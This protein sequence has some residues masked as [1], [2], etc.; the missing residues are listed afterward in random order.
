VPPADGQV[1][2]QP[3]PAPAADVLPP[4]K[5]VERERDWLRRN[6]GARYDTAAAL[7]SR[8]L[9]EAPGLHGGPRSS[10]GDAPTDLAAVRLY[11]TGSTT[12][13]D[14]AI[15]SAA[16]GPH[17]PLARC[18]ASGLR[19]LPSHRG[20]AIVRAALTPAERAW[21]RENMVVV[22]RSFLAALS[23][24]R[25]GLPG[26]TD[27]VL[28]SLTAR[29]TE[30][31]VPE[32]PD[33]LLFAPGTRFKVLRTVGG[34][35]PAVLMREMAA[36]ELDEQGQPREERVPLDEIALTGLDHLHALWLKAEDTSDEEAMGDPLP[37]EHAD[38]FRAA[39]GLLQPPPG[40]PG[41]PTPALGPGT[42]SQQGGN[43]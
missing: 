38:A 5:G 28:W 18:A 36:A 33:R 15:R 25:P 35:R 11:L 6:L 32:L 41:T 1:R 40:D 19:R 43:P 12:A 8:V 24:I 31:V 26:D 7:V 22:E 9:S 10:L 34:D 2:V 14:T 42:T 23:S 20:G 37:P 30:L 17:V 39:P 13:I 4:A 3:Q 21:Y 16:T 27:I 29:R